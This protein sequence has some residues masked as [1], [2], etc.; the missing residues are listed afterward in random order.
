MTAA[1]FFREEWG[2]KP[3]QEEGRDLIAALKPNKPVMAEVWAPR[4]PRHH[5]LL[6]VLYSRLRNGGAWEGG[7]D[8][9]LRWAKW[10]TGLVEEDFDHLGRAHWRTKSIKFTAMPQDEFKRWFDRVVYLVCAR[11]LGRND[12]VWLRDEVV[13]VVEGDLGKRAKEIKERFG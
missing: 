11:L 1:L 5:A 3:W 13:S 10:S 8:A 12:W 9:F 2:L 6:F 7:Q 4:N